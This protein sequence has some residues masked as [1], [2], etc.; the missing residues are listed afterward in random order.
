[1]VVKN[2]TSVAKNMKAY[3][4]RGLASETSANAP[5][6]G[7]ARTRHTHLACS[8]ISEYNHLF[9]FS[10]NHL[11]S[12]T[13]FLETTKLTIAKCN[14]QLANC[15]TSHFALSLQARQTGER[16]RRTLS[17][18]QPEPSARLKT[19]IGNG[20]FSSLQLGKTVVNLR[21]HENNLQGVVLL[22]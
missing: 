19:V 11:T 5:G 18:P 1:M 16:G 22:F 17:D 9:E 7:L 13:F 8:I 10:N 14:T 4:V 3:M 2:Q 6:I 20:F 21:S 12:G 15:T